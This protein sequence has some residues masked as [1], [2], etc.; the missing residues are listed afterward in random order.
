MIPNI[1]VEQLKKLQVPVPPMEK[2]LSFVQRYQ[3]VQDEI[4]VLKLKLQKSE[5][6]LHHMFDEESEG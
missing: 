1:G 3:A 2:Q 4:A 5:N 6:R